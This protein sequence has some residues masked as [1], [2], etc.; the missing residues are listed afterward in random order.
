[1]VTFEYNSECSP[2]TEISM[3]MENDITLSE[4]V[5]HCVEFARMMGYM[6]GSWEPVIKDIS[7]C[8]DEGFSITDWAFSQFV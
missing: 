7:N 4:Y 5:A 1:M 2:I 3:E 8:F 6:D